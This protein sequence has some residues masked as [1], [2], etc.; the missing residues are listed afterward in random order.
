MMWFSSSE[1]AE[2]DE[3]NRLG[4]ST[5]TGLCVL[6]PNKP[7]VVYSRLS[8]ND[9]DI[10]K[11]GKWLFNLLDGLCDRN[12]P[13]GTYRALR[14]LCAT[15]GMSAVAILY[16]LAHWTVSESLNFVGG[17]LNSFPS[18]F[19]GVIFIILLAISAFVGNN[20]R[21]TYCLSI[22]SG[23]KWALV[24]AFILLVIKGVAA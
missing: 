10:E 5:G 11:L 24:F 4:V 18:F 1:I 22:V 21:L 7:N 23:I 17:F 3:L 20:D 12:E 13:P 19:F 8:I 14:C 15:L 2:N 9:S 6:L 16:I